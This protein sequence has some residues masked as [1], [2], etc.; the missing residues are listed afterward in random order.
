MP[1]QQNILGS[2]S[3]LTVCIARIFDVD[4]DGWSSE[5]QCSAPE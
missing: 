3:A 4:Y 5:P 2:V 1:T